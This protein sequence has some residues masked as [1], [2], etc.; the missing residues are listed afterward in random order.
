MSCAVPPLTARNSFPFVPLALIESFGRAIT[1]PVLEL[2]TALSA[3]TATPS[4]FAPPTAICEL[5]A[6]GSVIV[7]A[8]PLTVAVKLAPW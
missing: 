6:T 7:F 2:S 4:A 5:V 3:P 8:T 1:T